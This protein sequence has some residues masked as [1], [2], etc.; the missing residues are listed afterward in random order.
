MWKQ[1]NVSKQEEERCQLVVKTHKWCCT[2]LYHRKQNKT[3]KQ[4][5]NNLNPK[6]VECRK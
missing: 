3:A 2:K 5:T 4:N 1:E 6:Q